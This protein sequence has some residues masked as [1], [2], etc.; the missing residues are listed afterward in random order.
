MF[1]GDVT[2]YVANDGGAKRTNSIQTT[3]YNKLS[4][5][6]PIYNLFFIKTLLS[7]DP[8]SF[9]FKSGGIFV[10]QIDLKFT[11]LRSGAISFDGY[12]FGII[13]E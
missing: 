12:L 10:Q 5:V 13:K 6:D 4:I 1:Y 8:D 3:Y 9:Y 7:P 2:V 11:N